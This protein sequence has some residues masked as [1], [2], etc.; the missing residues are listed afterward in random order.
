MR[1]VLIYMISIVVIMGAFL[2]F[3][4]AGF[5]GE[6]NDCTRD[7]P[8]TC[9]CERFEISDITSDDVGVIQPSNTWFNLY[10]IFTAA[11]VLAFL[12]KDR[13]T[14]AG[15]TA[16]NLMRSSSWIPDIYLFAVLFLGLGS[17]WFHASLTKWGGVFDGL[18]M[19]I[20]AAFL[21]FYTSIR[22][23]GRQ[24]LFWIGYPTFVILMTIFH[25]MGVDSFALIMI[26]V[27]AY[28]LLEVMIWIESGKFA[29]GETLPQVLWILAVVCILAATTFWALSQTGK[30][31]CDED[32]WFQP[33]GL[34]WHPLAGIMAVLLYFYW[35]HEEPA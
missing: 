19:Y 15:R 23:C 29:M 30:A 24:L 32:S 8:N 11:I 22:L 7:E 17:M 35:R 28:L 20:Y 4:A 2:A 25:G 1:A 5:P 21:V 18:S 13:R 12:N 6:R 26:L 9:F 27:V 14:F 31:L 33:H 34:L 16:P 10:S 3:V